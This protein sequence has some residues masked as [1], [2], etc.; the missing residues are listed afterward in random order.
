MTAT[1]ESKF[2]GELKNNL[3]NYEIV[4]LDDFPSDKEKIV[5][6]LPKENKKQIKVLD[7]TISAETVTEHHASK[8]IVICNR[9]ES[10]QKVY[11]DLMRLKSTPNINLKETDVENIICLHSRFLTKI[12]KKREN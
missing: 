7:Y 3:N 6:L 5:S 12:E 1:L 11:R 4:T 2:M 8:T 10:A 9:V